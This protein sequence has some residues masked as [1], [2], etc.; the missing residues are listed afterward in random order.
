M[1]ELDEKLDG[2]KNEW[3]NERTDRWTRTAGLL[4]D[5]RKSYISHCTCFRRCQG[6]QNKEETEG[7]GCDADPAEGKEDLASQSAV[8]CQ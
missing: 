4:I 7:I 6:L 2:Q 3:M 8:V 5:N 1:T